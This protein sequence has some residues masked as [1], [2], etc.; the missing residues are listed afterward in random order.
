MKIRIS[1]NYE[2]SKLQHWLDYGLSSS[3]LLF[4]SYA[5]GFT[6]ILALIAA[7]ALFPLLIKVLINEKRYG[8]II[9]FITSVIIPSLITYF[10]LDS[11]NWINRGTTFFTAASVSLVFFYFY[12]GLLRLTIPQ[13]ASD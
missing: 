13:W 5:Y 1:E 9:F 2:L 12:C 7:I 6:L 8:W 3:A 4:L 10:L 11:V